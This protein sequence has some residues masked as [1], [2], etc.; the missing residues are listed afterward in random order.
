VEPWSTVGKVMAKKGE[1]KFISLG[2]VGDPCSICIMDQL[3][4]KIQNVWDVGLVNEE[5][6]PDFNPIQFKKRVQSN[7]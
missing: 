7:K 4:G 6:M 1:A 5:E 2:P 3:V